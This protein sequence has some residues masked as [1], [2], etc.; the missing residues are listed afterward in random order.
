MPHGADSIGSLI[1]SNAAMSEIHQ[2]M[3]DAIL[4]SVAVW[5]SGVVVDAETGIGVRDAY[6][7]VIPP[8]IHTYTNESGVF[9]FSRVGAG[10]VLIRVEALGYE[11]WEDTVVVAD[12]PADL[13]ISLTPAPLIL[14]SL[15]VDG[16]ELQLRRL[17]E[18]SLKRH[19][20]RGLPSVAE[21]DVLRALTVLPGVSN[22]SDFSAVPYLRGAA[23]GYTTLTLDGGH[24]FNPYHLGGFFSA[25]PEEVVDE[26]TIIPGGIPRRSES[27]LGGRIEIEGRQARSDPAITANL[28]LT[29]AAASAEARLGDH[30]GGVVAVRRTYIDGVTHGLNR[31][32]LLSKRIPYAFMDL[33]ARGDWDVSAGQRVSI[34]GY[35]TDEGAYSAPNGLFSSGTNWNWDWGTGLISARYVGGTRTI[36]LWAS[37]SYSTFDMDFVGLDPEGGVSMDARSTQA[38]GRVAVGSSAEVGGVALEGGLEHTNYWLSHQIDN[39]GNFLRLVLPEMAIDDRIAGNAGYLDAHTALGPVGILVGVRL[40]QWSP[41]RRSWLPRVGASWE[42]SAEVTVGA[43][44]SRSTQAVMTLRN[45]ESPYSAFL[46]LDLLRA[47]PESAALPRGED[48]LLTG[49]WQRGS[50]G[51]LRLDLFRKRMRDVL[52]VAPMYRGENTPLVAADSLVSTSAV[53]TGFDVAGE[54]TIGTFGYIASVG[55]EDNEWSVPGHGTF[56]PRF[57]RAWRASVFATTKLGPA[58]R[59]GVRLLWGTGQ[60]Y[61][62]LAGVVGTLVPSG[63]SFAPSTSLAVLGDLNSLS[64]PSYMRAD[65]HWEREWSIT[66]GSH[67]SHLGVYLQLLNLFNRQNRLFVVPEYGP[68]GTTLRQAAQLPLLPTIGIRWEL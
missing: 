52:A 43:S 20:M 61:T 63:D 42:P 15:L 12:G 2:E 13:R 47:L 27:R 60:P 30:L 53:I 65:L 55:F 57:S 67:D 7:A 62:P 33:Y 35:V 1:C 16:G 28:G 51:T 66:M 44:W 34:S 56:T 23:P 50:H 10:M 37:A 68:N 59:F 41:G 32:G 5:L 22:A 21:P 26:V 58:S 48:V 17:G 4:M 49:T 40:E 45:E 54:G 6:V 25:V 3:T 19:E 38:N 18:T 36:P 64:L 8:D 31:V 11:P 9:R 24:L 46:G 14:P 39:P 29:S